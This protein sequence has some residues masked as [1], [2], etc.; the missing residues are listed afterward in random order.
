MSVLFSIMLTKNEAICIFFFSLQLWPTRIGNEFLFSMAYCFNCF[1]HGSWE[2]SRFL[3]ISSRSAVSVFRNARKV[4]IVV[5]STICGKRNFRSLIRRSLPLFDDNVPG[6]N[7]NDTKYDT[8]LIVNLIQ[9]YSR[10]MTSSRVRRKMTIG[11]LYLISWSATLRFRLCFTVVATID[12]HEDG[13]TFAANGRTWSKVA[14]NITPLM[15]G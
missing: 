4:G 1:M 14:S 5:W 13:I 8:L 6:L 9:A 2:T 15:F 3:I 10:A 11:P 12:F 7:L